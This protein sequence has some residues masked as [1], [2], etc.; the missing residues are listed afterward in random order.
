MCIRDSYKHGKREFVKNAPQL[1][2]ARDTLKRCSRELDACKD[3]AARARI[4]KEAAH[5]ALLLRKTS[6][7]LFAAIDGPKLLVVCKEAYLG[8]FAAFAAVLS[9]TAAKV[10][11]GLDLGTKV[12]NAVNADSWT[13]LLPPLNKLNNFVINSSMYGSMT[14][15]GQLSVKLTV[16][17][18]ACACTRGFAASSIHPINA[19]NTILCPFFCN[20]GPRSVHNCP[21]QFTAAHLTLG[22]GSEFAKCN[23]G[24]AEPMTSFIIPF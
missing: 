14:S 18:H 17:A 8:T 1:K 12:A 21:K 5:A 2:A 20:L 3:D 16:A 9:S 19:G 6:T 13:T 7:S 23:A 11:I 15:V 4:I 22:C 24:V 10:G